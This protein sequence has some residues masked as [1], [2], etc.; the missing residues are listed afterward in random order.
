MENNAPDEH[1]TSSAL[2]CNMP[3]PRCAACHPGAGKTLW[4]Q[5]CEDMVQDLMLQ[6]W[7]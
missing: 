3:Q 1:V 6:T 2:Q 4:L 5:Q 7:Q